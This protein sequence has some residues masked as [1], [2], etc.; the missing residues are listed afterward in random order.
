M[1]NDILCFRSGKKKIF[2]TLGLSI[3]L[4]SRDLKK[5]YVFHK[6]FLLR[7]TITYDK[8]KKKSIEIEV[9]FFLLINHLA[10]KLINSDRHVFRKL[11]NT[12]ST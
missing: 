6:Y 7:K 8:F 11:G 9:F 4:S 3:S 5:S 12:H 1:L 2:R 10:I